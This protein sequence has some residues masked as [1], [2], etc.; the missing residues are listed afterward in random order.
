QITIGGTDVRVEDAPQEIEPF[1]DM[2]RAF[3]GRMRSDIR[4]HHR[5]F[6]IT[7]P[8]LDTTEMTTLRTLLHG[9]QPVTAGGDMIGTD[10]SFLVRGI[11][12]QPITSSDWVVSFELREVSPT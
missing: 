5:V 11:R 6:R 12:I 4:G 8:P 2:D 7:T 3:S 10:A 1:G 9:D